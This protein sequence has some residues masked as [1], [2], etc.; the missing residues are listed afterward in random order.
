MCKDLKQSIRNLLDQI[1]I[2]ETSLTKEEREKDVDLWFAWECY[3]DT[4][5]SRPT[6]VPVAPPSPRLTPKV[7]KVIKEYRKYDN[8]VKWGK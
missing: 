4:G 3:V 5:K 8:Q 7:A 1:L 2:E 6:D